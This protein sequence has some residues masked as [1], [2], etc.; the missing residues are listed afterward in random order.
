MNTSTK[1]TR[2]TF[3]EKQN[4]CVSWPIWS[5]V[6]MCLLETENCDVI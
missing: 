2:E 4:I 1:D 5:D 6:K 3:K